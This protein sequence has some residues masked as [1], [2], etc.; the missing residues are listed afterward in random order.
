MGTTEQ[1]PSLKEIRAKIRRQRYISHCLKAVLLPAGFLFLTL[2]LT[3]LVF[4]FYLAVFNI[5]GISMEPSLKHDDTVIALRT[6][7]VRAFDIIAFYSRSKILI[8]RVI[9]TPSQ[10]VDIKEDGTV[11]VDGRVLREDYVKE[12]SRGKC[13]ISLPVTLKEDEFFVMGDQRAVSLDSRADFI[14]PVKREHI[15]GRI[16]FAV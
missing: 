1:R 16:L 5:E 13:S 12:K 2:I 3:L 11:L 4:T 15:L 7:D 9:A 10:T 6:K 14:G 8:K